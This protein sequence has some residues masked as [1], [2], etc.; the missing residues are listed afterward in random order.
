MVIPAYN[1]ADNI[2]IVLSNMPATVCGKKTQAI[3]V[4]DGGSDGTEQVVRSLGF[5]VIV[6]PIN[7]GGGAALR[8]G[9]QAAIDRK[10]DIVVTLDAD[11]Q[12]LPEEMER[13][14]EPI[15][16]NQADFVNG[17]R[18]LGSF[19]RENAIRSMGVVVFK[20]DYQYINGAA[21]HRQL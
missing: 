6:N 11:G 19:E 18:V 5:P 10:A 17:S 20:L 2:Q 8:V 4:V 3:V 16:N 12:H 9:Y 14:V 1:E 13:L 21:D 15:L 7:R